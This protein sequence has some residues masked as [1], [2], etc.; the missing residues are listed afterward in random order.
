M[1]CQRFSGAFRKHRETI[2]PSSAGSAGHL[3][4]ERSRL[5]GENRCQRR[6]GRLALE[7]APASEHLVQQRAER[8][9]VRAVIHRLAFRLL[10]RHVGHGAEDGALGGLRDSRP[11]SS[12]VAVEALERRRHQLR[13]A[14]IEHFDD[15]R[16]GDHHVA[17]LE[18]AV[19]DA[20]RV[21]G[22]QRIG[23]LD[24]VG[25]RRFQRKRLSGRS[26][27]PGAGP[28]RAPSR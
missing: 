10:G 15:A 24:G 17:R 12:R 5:G 25:N 9:D 27:H 21:G 3:R 22:G 26:P 18:I 20:G 19:D 14:E 13:E 6:D 8:E 4:G 1:L 23:D 28:G 7:R 2:R 11:A 16:V